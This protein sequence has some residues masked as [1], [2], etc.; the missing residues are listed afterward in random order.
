MIFYSFPIFLL[1]IVSILLIFDFYYLFACSNVVESDLKPFY[2]YLLIYV[3]CGNATFN[4]S[5]S[6][7]PTI[8]IHC[9]PTLKS[10]ECAESGP[11]LRFIIDNYDKPLAEVYFFAHGHDVAWHY[12]EPYFQKV[13]QVLKSKELVTDS[14]GGVE[15]VYNTCPTINSPRFY[16]IYNELFKNTSM[17]FNLFTEWQ[18]PCCGTFFVKSSQIR[19]RLK[20]D[21][22]QLFENMYNWNKY[23]YPKTGWTRSSLFYCSRIYEAIWHIMF[24]NKSKISIPS[25]CSYTKYNACWYK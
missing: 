22:Q 13:N 12:I 25:H 16:T 17:E 19:K 3:T 18:Y 8:E 7:I 5:T 9:D 15:C 20:S 21:Y 4:V 1:C 6:P 2:K 23:E 24:A 10:I 14:Y 11:Y